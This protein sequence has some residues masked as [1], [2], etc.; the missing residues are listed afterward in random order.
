M[1]RFT[2]ASLFMNLKDENKQQH[3]ERI[4]QGKMQAKQEYL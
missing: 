1:P 4:K 3:P 2:T